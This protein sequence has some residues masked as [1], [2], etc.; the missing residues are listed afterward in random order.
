MV[1][2]GSTKTAAPSSVSVCFPSWTRV[3]DGK[4]AG[5]LGEHAGLLENFFDFAHGAVELQ[6]RA[7]ARDDAG[8]FLAAM[9]ERVEAEIGEVGRLRM[10][11]DAEDATVVVEVVVVCGH[12]HDP[13]TFVFILRNPGGNSDRNA[14]E[15]SHASAKVAS[16]RS[17]A[18]VQWRG[19]VN[20]SA[21][22]SYPESIAK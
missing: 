1:R 18:G 5:K 13:M 22:K 16:T 9:L 6:F 8:G 19:P 7:V 20:G 2:M 11:E 4:R 17:T 12:Q 14:G 21:K 3:A 15:T 10:T